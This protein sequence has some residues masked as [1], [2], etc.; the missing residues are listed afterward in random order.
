[1]TVAMYVSSSRNQAEAAKFLLGVD[2]DANAKTDSNKATP[3]I[4]AV[5]KGNKKV[6]DVLVSHPTVDLTAQVNKV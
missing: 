3:V 5:A 2:A 6:F 1:M 4:I